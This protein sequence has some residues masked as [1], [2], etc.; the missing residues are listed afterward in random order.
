MSSKMSKIPAHAKLRLHDWRVSILSRSSHGV[1]FDQIAR[2]ANT[3]SANIN[4]PDACEINS[5]SENNLRP[6]VSGNIRV[7]VW[8]RLLA[9]CRDVFAPLSTGQRLQSP[10]LEPE[11]PHADEVESSASRAEAE[12]PK[13]HWSSLKRPDVLWEFL[14]AESEK[15]IDNRGLNLDRPALIICSTLT[16]GRRL[17]RYFTS[18]GVEAHLVTD[19]DEG[20]GVLQ[21]QPDAW[22]MAILDLDSFGGILEL[23]DDLIDFRIEAPEVPVLLLSSGFSRDDLTEERLPMCDASIRSPALS[24]SILNGARA[25]IENNKSWRHRCKIPSH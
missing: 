14:D 7:G 9:A 2:R 24:L 6:G 18:Q 13:A 10:S 12:V 19:V 5:Q 25:A 4:I 15:I 22:S 16:C 3:F 17:A 8:G 20:F 21:G 23:S 11:N 1:H